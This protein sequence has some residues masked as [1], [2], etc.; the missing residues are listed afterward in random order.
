MARGLKSKKV[1]PKTNGDSVTARYP[2]HSVEKAL[3][4]PRAIIDQNAGREC[5]DRESAQFVG[6]GFTGPYRVE[7][8]SSIKYGLLERP[9]A[10]HIAV[11]DRARQVLRPQ[12]PGDEIDALRQAVLNAPDIAEVYQHY[13]GENLPDGHFF[14]NAL[15]DKF[16]I[17]ANKVSEFIDVFRSSLKAAHLIE[18]NDNK[19]RIL[20][21]TG[22]QQTISNPV[23]FKKLSQ[24]VKI[25]ATDSCFV[26]MPFGGAIGSYF[27]HIY[28]PAIKKAG[29]RPI[30]ADDE[31][32]GTE[33]Y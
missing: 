2:R 18:E 15:T 22:S 19:Q 9:R 20:D 30:R 24:G 4:I 1:R 3:R 8:S 11:T 17:P 33:D 10:G 25:D 14:E 13:R 23:S 21:I 27:E 6:V 31:I 5:T 12:K 32:F 7:L 28:E 29:L 16:N 26:M